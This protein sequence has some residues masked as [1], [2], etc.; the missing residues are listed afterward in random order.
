MRA[1]ATFFAVL[2]CFAVSMAQ[3]QTPSTAP[4]EPASV[5]V[6]TVPAPAD[7][8]PD[9]EVEV[10]PAVEVTDPAPA[11]ANRRIETRT[12]APAPATGETPAPAETLAPTGD[13]GGDVDGAIAPTQTPTVPPQTANPAADPLQTPPEFGL[14][15]PDEGDLASTA[16]NSRI[17]TQDLGAFVDGMIKSL[18]QAEQVSGVTV[19]VVDRNGP[20]LLR[21]Y[22][23]ASF[24]PDVAV[25]PQTTLFRIGSVSK[26]FTYIAAMQL[27]ERGQLD[28]EADINDYLPDALE[29]ADPDA[30]GPIRVWHL[31]THTAGFEDTA[32]GHL[33]MRDGDTVLAV[34]EYLK[35]YRPARVRPPG[36]RAVYSNYSVALLGQIIALQA[37]APFEDIVERQI[38]QPL[39]MQHTTFRE[40]LPEGDP[41]RVS[42]ALSS[43]WATGHQRK[44]GLF[45]GNRF[46]H[47]AHASAAGGASSTA[48]DMGRYMRMLLGRGEMDGARVLSEQTF[49]RM[50]T[51][52]FRNADAVSGFA[53]GFFATRV[54]ELVSLGHGGATLDMMSTMAVLPEAGLG[55]FVSTNSST[56][57]KLVSR[58]P[59]M[60]FQRYVEAARPAPLPNPDPELFAQADRFAGSYANLRRNESTLEHVFTG[61]DAITVSIDE[62]GIMRVTVGDDTRAF[63]RESE[64]VF[65][66][67]EGD[68]RITFLLD[69]SGRA[70]TFV[71]GSGH[72]VAERLSWW[73]H[74]QTLILLLAAVAVFSVLVLLMAWARWSA[75][76]GYATAV[77]PTGRVPA[78]VLG[79]T[80]LAWLGFFVTAVMVSV[81]FGRLGND[82]VQKY[83]TE[84]LPHAVLVA[85]IAAVLSLIALLTLPL[86]W[87]AHWGFFRKLRHT[88]VVLT[89]IAA[90]TAMWIWNML[91]APIGIGVG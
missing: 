60:I 65:R 70:T 84:L 53:H 10:D 9:V 63:V 52:R 67:V 51:V 75:R 17:D 5:E 38:L 20:L 64:R 79:L 68:D 25:D 6:S 81:E 30:L 1:S 8:S 91:L 88:L 29:I 56:G 86:A 71:P 19:A 76:R 89:M 14:P 47:I 59:E 82:L 26:T 37:G 16:T 13:P 61:M 48:A 18:M 32:L 34:D 22:G 90:C 2:A 31:M 57:R 28:L 85:Q 21:G 78:V 27:V 54:G 44:G 36:A 77:K 15:V 11:A 69:E 74:P 43:D 39:G 33:I 58:V 40:K 87:T 80:S 23:K 62:K 3:A 73:N 12:A 55:V 35:R 45:V 24:D 42:D 4:V 50:S 49:D 83:P 72:W 7:L 41:R 46:E 66:G